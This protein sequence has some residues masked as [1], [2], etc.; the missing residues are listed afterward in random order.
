VLEDVG[1]DEA[2]ERRLRRG[3]AAQ[4]LLDAER[5]DAIQPRRGLGRRLGAR[6]HTHDGDV[7]ARLERRAQRAAG[8]AELED[9]PGAARDV[10]LDVRTVRVIA[11]QPARL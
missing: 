11:A 6:L 5:D 2:V 3:R 9:A 4:E 8:A 1:R 10:A 7:L